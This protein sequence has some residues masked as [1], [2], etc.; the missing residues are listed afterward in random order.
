MFNANQI[1]ARMNNNTKFMNRNA[2]RGG[3]CSLSPGVTSGGGRFTDS[4]TAG[5]N[6]NVPIFVSCL[7]LTIGIIVIVIMVAV[8][9]TK[10]SGYK[11]SGYQVPRFSQEFAAWNPRGYQNTNISQNT[12]I[13]KADSMMTPVTDVL[14]KLDTTNTAVV[15]SNAEINKIPETQVSQAVPRDSYRRRL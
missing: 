9:L 10:K 7:V 6:F 15:P 2:I 12:S 13:N 14:T 3:G 4:V 8:L 11:K 5:N 1:N